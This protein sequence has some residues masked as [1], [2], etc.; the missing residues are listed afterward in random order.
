MSHAGESDSAAPPAA[1]PNGSDDLRVTADQIRVIA[2]GVVRHPR[3]GAML[4]D[5]IPEPGT[6]RVVHRP[7]GGGVEF[8]E[9]AADTVVREF[10]EEYGLC[11]RVRRLLGVLEN[12]F[13]FGGRMLHSVMFVYDAELVGPAAHEF[14]SLQ[15]RDAPSI[16]AVWR[17]I[18]GV[19]AEFIV[20]GIEELAS[21]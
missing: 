16:R 12:V 1:R 4:V 8:L 11:V 19:R 9:R 10:D 14:D 7:P 2:V 6:G 20:P 21:S 13:Q 3:T 18:T 15:S 17:P 5:E